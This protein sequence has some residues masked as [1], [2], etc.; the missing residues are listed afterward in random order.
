MICHLSDPGRYVGYRILLGI[1]DSEASADVEHL[2]CMPQ[3]VSYLSREAD[4]YLHLPVERVAFEDLRAHVAVESRHLYIAALKRRLH[5]VVRL[6]GV[7]RHAE[8]RVHLAR[9]DG[10]ERVRIES[11]GEPQQH[12]LRHPRLSRG[13]VQHLELVEVVHNEISDAA[14]NAV[15]DVRVGLVCAVEEHL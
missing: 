5:E 1:S 12:L 10:L 15:F 13:P 8:L 2:Y 6:A 14:F 3:P 11:A 4:E 9:V 7:D